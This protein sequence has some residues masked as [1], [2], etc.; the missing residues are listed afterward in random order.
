MRCRVTSRPS[1]FFHQ[2]QRIQSIELIGVNDTPVENHFI[3]NKVCLLKVE[4]DVQFAHILEIFVQCLN[5]RVDELQ[6]R[7]LVLRRITPYDEI[8]EGVC[9]VQFSDS[10]VD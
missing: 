6:Q 3:E 4:H 2:I 9:D 10:V 5:E 1:V 8:P 7:K